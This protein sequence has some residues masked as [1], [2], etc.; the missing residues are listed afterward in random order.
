MGGGRPREFA[1]RLIALAVMVEDWDSVPSTATP[2]SVLH[3][4]VNIHTRTHAHTN[5]INEAGEMARSLKAHAALAEDSGLTPHIH[6]AAHNH[7]QLQFQESPYPLLA[8][9]GKHMVCLHTCRRNTHMHKFFKNLLKITYLQRS[10]SWGC[11]QRSGACL[12]RTMF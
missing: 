9:H 2:S 10:M 7:L 12:V 5:K 3:R 4:H 1:Q 8:E 11:S 6:K